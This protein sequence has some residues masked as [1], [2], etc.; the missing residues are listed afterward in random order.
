MATFGGIPRESDLRDSG[1]GVT[2][3]TAA[4]LFH[5]VD[6]NEDSEFISCR[7][8]LDFISRVCVHSIGR[9]RQFLELPY[10][11]A[12]TIIEALYMY[13]YVYIYICITLL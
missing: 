1:I 12:E 10:E 7:I 6:N 13:I 3:E 8:S 9:P 2:V 4:K 5:F 11:P